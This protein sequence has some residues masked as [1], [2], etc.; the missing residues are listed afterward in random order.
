MTQ[1]VRD[2]DQIDLAR[3]YLTGSAQN[4]LLTYTDLTYP[5]YKPNWHHRV[6][7]RYLED[8]ATG[9]VKR[10]M[11]LV[12]PRY[13]KSELSSIR[14]PAWYLGK[15]PD[16]KVILASY[17]DWFSLQFGKHARNVCQTEMHRTIFPD[18]KVRKDSSSGSLWELEAG[19]RFVAVGRGGAVTGHG[20]H[21]LILDDLIKNVQEAYSENVRNT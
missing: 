9:K 17:S 4:N 11:I 2:I 8:A 5:K 16:K 20:A 14:L 10:L 1:D 13:G 21:L 3:L 12:P 19:G 6:I 18:S 15:Y 7:A